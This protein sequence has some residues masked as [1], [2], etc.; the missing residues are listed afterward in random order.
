MMSSLRIA[1][2]GSSLVSTYW[3]GAAT[4]YRGMIR[5]LAA[6]GHRITF[7]EPDALD[8]QSHRDMQDPE[9]AQV[10]IYPARQVSQVLHAL[11]SARDADIIVKASGVGVHD[12]LLE[13][14]ALGLRRPGNLVIFWDVDAPATLERVTRDASDVFGKLA[15]EYDLILTYGGGTNEL[16]RDLIAMFGLGFPRSPR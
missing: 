15:R 6:R 12:G 16:Q 2:F 14:A 5:A 7:Y 4:Y 3:N 10:V 13:S 8:R 1:F 11:D 9:W